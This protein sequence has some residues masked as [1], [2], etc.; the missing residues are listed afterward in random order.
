MAR[1]RKWFWHAGRLLLLAGFV[2]LFTLPQM[3]SPVSRPVDAVVLMAIFVPTYLAPL[4]GLR[5]KLGFIAVITLAGVALFLL[6]GSIGRHYLWFIGGSVCVTALSLG[7][8][9]TR[10]SFMESV[11]RVQRMLRHEPSPE[12]ARLLAAIRADRKLSKS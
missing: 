11:R 7:N 3:H 8:N 5:E 2:W 12:E 4:L 9:S 1:R 10:L 6:D